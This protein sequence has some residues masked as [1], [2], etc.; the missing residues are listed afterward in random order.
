MNS[1]D[2]MPRTADTPH[3]RYGHASSVQDFLKT[4][5]H[6]LVGK[7]SK[8]VIDSRFDSVSGLQIDS[9][10]VA[11]RALREQLDYPEFQ[12]WFI[13]L[14]HRPLRVER[15]SDVVVL[16]PTTVFVVEFKVGAHRYDSAA[17]WQ[18]LDYA[19]DLRDYHVESYK[20]R[21]VPILCATNAAW[22]GSLDDYNLSAKPR[23]EDL[24][25]TNGSNLA[26]WFRKC[27]P[28]LWH[29]TSKQHITTIQYLC[30][31]ITCRRHSNFL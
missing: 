12:D 6:T 22:S 2:S 26:A 9:W 27:Q 3:L 23:V 20:R 24:V 7:L 28:P 1:F 18:A 17:R 31:K 25:C 15:R 13:V 5:D 14:E 29:K 4:D 10:P 11:I 19:R 8:N 30:S 16:S 21:I